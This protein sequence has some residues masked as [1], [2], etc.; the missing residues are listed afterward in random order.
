MKAIELKSRTDK[1][2]HLKIDYQLDKSNRKVRVI[3][4]FD[5]DIDEKNEEELWLKSISQN[6]AFDFL[7]DQ[8]EDIY[9]LN[10]GVPFND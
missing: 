2:G 8:S 7:H 10:D 5:E 1:E 3:I 6:P 4:L 9:S